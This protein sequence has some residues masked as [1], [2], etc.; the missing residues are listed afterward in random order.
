MKLQNSIVKAFIFDMD[1]TLIDSTGIWSEIDRQFFARRGMEV[2]SD[3][4]EKIAH[5][6]LQQAA[7]FTK[8]TYGIKESVEEIIQEWKQDSFDMYATQ[9]TLKE[10]AY[11]ILDFLKSKN[12]KIALAT[13]NDKELY[14]VC[15]KRLNILHFFDVIMDVNSVKSGKDSIKLYD[16][17]SKKLDSERNETVVLEDISLGLKTA[18]NGGYITVGVHDEGSIKQESEKK[19]YSNFYIYS[20]KDLSKILKD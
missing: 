5:I 9:I 16:E 10:Y 20:L 3:Y 17:I 13:A 15:L 4:A 1:G 14:E 7:V 11:E 19:K 6:G 8:E 2:P 18:K 12:I